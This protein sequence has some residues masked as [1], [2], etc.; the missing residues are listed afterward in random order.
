VSTIHTYI[1]VMGGDGKGCMSP[2]CRYGRGA[3]EWPRNGSV[4]V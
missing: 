3:K 1:T 4:L 2:Q